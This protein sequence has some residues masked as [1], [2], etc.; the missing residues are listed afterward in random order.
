MSLELNKSAAAVL[1]AGVVAMTAGFVANLLVHPHELEE[2][3]YVIEGTGGGQQAAPEEEV[4]ASV[5]PL[6][7]EADP[8]SGETL[9]RACQACHTVEQGGPNKVGP[10][11]WNVVG[12]DIATHE[13]FSYSDALTGLEGEWTYENLNAFLADPRGYAPGTK[14]TYGGMNDVE[15]RAD[16]IAYLRSLSDSPAPLPTPEEVEAAEQ[17]AAEA[18]AE[19]EQPAEGEGATDGEQAAEG[20]QSVDPAQ[21]VAMADPA[22]GENILRQC[23]ACHTF[24][25]GGPNKVGPNLH[26]IVGAQVAAA[27]GF[28]Y[29][30]AMQEFGGEW[31]IERLWQ[32]LQ[33]PRG[34]VPGTRMTFGG[35]RKEEDLAGMIRYLWEN[36]E[37]PPELPQAGGESGSGEGS[38]GGSEGGGEESGEGRA[39]DQG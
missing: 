14:M 8:A 24:E 23:T 15:D 7:G 22:D 39:D 17:A 38:G 30:D 2:N 1:T 10:N 3:V 36:T 18:E 25:A 32:Y 20:A 35:I 33:D 12:A 4:L 19:A 26:N 11:L 13:G 34:V 27:E 5:I 6:L 31:T 9:F 28:T 21:Q 29:S 37:N 16:I